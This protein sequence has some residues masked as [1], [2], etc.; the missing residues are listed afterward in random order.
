MAFPRPPH[1]FPVKHE[2]Q[3][4]S[5]IWKTWAEAVSHK[6]RVLSN[7][8]EARI[9]PCLRGNSPLPKET[10]A[11]ERR[12]SGKSRGTSPGGGSK[13]MGTGRPYLTFLALV[14]F[15]GRGM[16]QPAKILPPRPAPPRDGLVRPAALQK[17]IVRAVEDDE[18]APLF[19]GLCDDPPAC[20]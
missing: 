1:N 5:G 9:W 14:V 10:K 11:R 2:K 7:Q 18:A 4:L 15:S 13:P 8:G 17:P 3:R 20:G 6:T 16:A 19:G 12:R